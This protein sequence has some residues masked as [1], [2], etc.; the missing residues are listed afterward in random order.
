MGR[1]CVL[2]DPTVNRIAAGEVVERPASV[3]K[4]LIEN[5]LDAGATRIVIEIQ[6]GGRRLIRVVDDG[7]GMDRDDA[8]L[9]LER[10]ATSKLRSASDLEGVRTL[11]FRGEALPSIAAVSRF[12]LRT[13]PE[14][15]HG[16]EIEVRGGK[17]LAVREVGVARGTVVEVAGL[18]FNLP[19]R[20][21]FLR[22]EATELSHVLR[23]VSRFALA[24]PDVRFRLDH[25]TRTLLD[26]PKAA[27]AAERAHHVYGEQAGR[28]LPFDHE[29]PGLRVRGLA[30]RPTEGLPRRDGQHVFVNGRVVQDRVLTHAIRQAY[31]NTMPR[32]RFPAAL[33]FVEIDPSAVD[34]NV[35]P[36]K[37]EVRF[38]SSS[39]VHDA[40]RHAVGSAFGA[41]GAVPDLTELRPQGELSREL[42]SI[43][44]STVRYLQSHGHG[45]GPPAPF[46]ARRGGGL[47]DRAA[48]DPTAMGTSLAE[49][50][51]R[52]EGW[53]A[54]AQYRDSYIVAED[55]DG[56]V[57]VDQH[58]AHERVLFE[59]YLGEAEADRVEVQRLMFPVTVE[60]AA[61]QATVLSDEIEEFRRLGFELEPFGERAFRIDGVPAILGE[62]DPVT[63]L[64][65]LL[66][67]A[68][69]A[70]SAASE[71]DALRHKLVTSAACQAAIKVNHPLSAVG[72][73]SLLEDLARTASP[74]TCP[75]GRPVLFRIRLEEIERG[76]RRR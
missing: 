9:A 18:F 33:V 29:R 13:A 65:E 53:R 26:A 17:I 11:G 43:A 58:A 27:S 2:D 15:G 72:M 19:A 16:T 70:G 32:D 35:H 62:V 28:L 45:D 6:S 52:L 48:P 40:V 51:P 24:R 49:P 22:S 14:D 30:G 41:E 20:R 68:R 46:G 42:G 57:L 64:R 75:H 36:Q 3:A 31:G 25:G 5:S 63:C 21:K 4:E 8:L 55:A 7:C 1:I 67:E 23:W 38:A 56:I 61:D 76:F 39:E 12:T 54:L 44:A 34:V 50:R 69:G 66:G 60:L 73:D 10:H 59:Q 47:Y 71:V 74:T 37:T